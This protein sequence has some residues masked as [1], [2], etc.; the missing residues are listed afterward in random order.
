M[1]GIF[2]SVTRVAIEEILLTHCNESKYGYVISKEEFGRLQDEILS[3]FL[4][5]RNL[6]SQGDKLLGRA[7][8]KMDP[9]AGK[10]LGRSRL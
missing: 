9:S 7:A 3:L 2:E 1:A 5:S 6:K 4:T 10:R 8:P